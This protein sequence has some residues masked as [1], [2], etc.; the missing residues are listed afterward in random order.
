MIIGTMIIYCSK[1]NN[2]SNDDN[3][4]DYENDGNSNK[5]TAHMSQS[6][7]VVLGCCIFFDYSSL[8]SVLD[9]PRR[10]WNGS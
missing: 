4:E 6:Y 1:N 2:N 9:A 8:N 3:H 5:D 7:I 10:R